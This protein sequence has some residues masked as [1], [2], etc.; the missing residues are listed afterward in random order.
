MSLKERQPMAV[1]NRVYKGLPDAPPTEVLE[2]LATY[3]VAWL[4]DATGLNLMDPAIRP[5]H[6]PRR[7]VGPAVTAHVQP[8]DFGLVPYA[9]DLSRPGDVLIIDGRG[10]TTRSNWGDYFSTWAQ[11]LGIIGTVVDG[12]TRDQRGIIDVDYPVFARAVTPHGPTLHG[13][14][15]VNGPV[16]CGGVAVLPGDIVVADSEGVIVIPLRNLA[17]ALAS[18]REKAGMED[19]IPA[20]NGR[21]N[22]HA[23]YSRMF[24]GK[25]NIEELDGSWEDAR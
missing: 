10:S 15:E 16:S 6:A 17:D 3:E 25:T 7:I 21:E 2:E 14:S 4:S 5:I 19:L 8:G 22:Y 11:S 9:L 24:E 23:F 13:A 12:A 20:P 1:K 18:V